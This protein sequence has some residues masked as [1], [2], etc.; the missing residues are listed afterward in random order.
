MH[1][2]KE[3]KLQGIELLS[4]LSQGDLATKKEDYMI[5]SSPGRKSS[6]ESLR[7]CAVQHTLISLFQ[8]NL[9]CAAG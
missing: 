9:T 1:E 2:S 6:T 5:N 3:V 4:C 7:D 8:A